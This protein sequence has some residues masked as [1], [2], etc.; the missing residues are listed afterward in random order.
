MSLYPPNEQ[1]RL[2]AVKRYDI[3]DTPPDG[4]F[5]RVVALA[6]RFF[7]VPLAIISI[8][9]NDRIWFKSHPVLEV[10]QIGRDLGLCASAILQD[11]VYNLIDASIDPRSLANPLVA[12]EFGLRFYAAAPLRTSDGFNLGTICVI[13]FEPRSISEA[14]KATLQDLAA[15][16]IDELELRLSA[17]KTIEL[18]VA[19]RTHVLQ[20]EKAEQIAKTDALTELKNRR[21]FDEDIEA[22]VFQAS[23]NG[24]NT[25][26]AFVDIDGFKSV[27][28]ILGHQQ[29]DMLLKTFAKAIQHHFREDTTYRFGG[30]EFAL[31][32][33]FKVGI[34]LNLV[35][36]SIQRR[37]AKVIVEIHAKGFEQV[38][39]SIGIATAAEANF[40]SQEAV[41]L[42]DTRMYME[43]NKRKKDGLAIACNEQ[44]CL[45]LEAEQQRLAQLHARIVPPETEIN[46]IITSM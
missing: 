4:T 30:D 46:L 3:L 31:L 14:E 9:D 38:S 13:D 34:S 42:A 1:Q 7:N 25:V 17:R 45:V 28:D 37:M 44:T 29:G 27:N 26:V 5:D 33:P 8:V 15:I 22:Y 20:K 36:E 40:S 35:Q 11:D 19:L 43:K 23:Q 6:A 32:I 2:A 41:R 18:E 16:V 39:A 12:G 24:D 21:A 10:E